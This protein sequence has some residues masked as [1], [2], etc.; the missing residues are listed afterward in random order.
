MKLGNSL[1]KVPVF[2]RKTDSALLSVF[3]FGGFHAGECVERRKRLK[4]T[5]VFSSNRQCETYSSH[6]NYKRSWAVG[7][8]RWKGAVRIVPGYHIWGLFRML[9]AN[10]GLAASSFCRFG[11][12]NWLLPPQ[13]SGGSRNCCLQERPVWALTGDLYHHFPS[14]HRIRHLYVRCSDVWYFPL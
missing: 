11:C 12:L 8:C 9:S 6:P 1:K 4:G 7:S 10:S 5:T 2:K 14:S 13:V 3:L